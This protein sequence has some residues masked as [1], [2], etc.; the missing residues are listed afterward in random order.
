M[1]IIDNPVKKYESYSDQLLRKSVFVNG[2]INKTNG[3]V[4]GY[5]KKNIPFEYNGSTHSLTN[6]IMIKKSNDGPPESV[7]QKGDSGALVCLNDEKK[8]LGMVVGGYKQYTY[9]IPMDTILNATK[10]SLT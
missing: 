1:E 2:N 6:L 10:T 3:V 9:L 5:T 7:S 4:A 8:A